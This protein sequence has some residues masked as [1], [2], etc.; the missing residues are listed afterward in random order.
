[1]YWV[2]GLE[3]VEMIVIVV[4][5]FCGE[6]YGFE[7]VL[8]F[9]LEVCVIVFDFFGF[10]EFVLLLGCCYDFDEYVGWFRDFVVIV[11]LGVVVFGYFFGLIV[12]FVVVVKG[13]FIFCLIFFNLIGVFV[14]E[15]LKGVMIC[16]V[17]LYYV[18][19]VCFLEKFGIVLLCNCIIVWVMSIMMV[20]MGDFVFCC[21]IYD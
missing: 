21:F 14:F 19:G 18:F 10:G 11:V 2:Y 6:Y 4:Y 7:F 9:L 3:D 1:M 12:V 13:L 20:K 17:V 8:V 5:G 15:G 16:L